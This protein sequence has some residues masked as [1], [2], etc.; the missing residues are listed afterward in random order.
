VWSVQQDE[1]TRVQSKSFGAIADVYDRFRPGPPEEAITWLLPPAAADV[2]ELGAG[3][4]ALTRLLTERVAH[5]RAVEPDDRMRAV[6]ADRVPQADVV[7][8]QAEKIPAP[9]ASFDA[10]IVASA[11]HWV[12]EERAVPEVARVL[13]PGGWLSLLWNGPDRTVDW[14]RSVFAGGKTLSPEEIEAWDAR[15]RGRHVVDLGTES[16]FHEPERRLIHWTLPMT[17]EE[18]LGMVSTYSV[19]ITM[20]TSRRQEYAESVSRYLD[21]QEALAGAGTLAMSMPMR[22]L[23]WRAALR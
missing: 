19:A 10:V 12:D 5:V 6:L 9:A 15:R 21:T 16:P 18:V 11:W 2:L 4:G 7:A 17:K 1:Q 3:T 8:G 23:C 22:C 20:S 13:R 14:V